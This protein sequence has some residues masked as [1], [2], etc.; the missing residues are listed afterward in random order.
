MCSSD[1]KNLSIFDKM[2]NFG[3]KVELQ[4]PPLKRHQRDTRLYCILF[5]TV[6]S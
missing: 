4:T 3:Q 2:Y 1:K 5:D 6:Y